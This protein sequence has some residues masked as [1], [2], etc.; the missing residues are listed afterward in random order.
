MKTGDSARNQL[1][2][3]QHLAASRFIILQSYK[4]VRSR[5]SKHS[6]IVA[7]R[8]D[9]HFARIPAPETQLRGDQAQG[10]RPWPSFVRLRSMVLLA[11]MIEHIYCNPYILHP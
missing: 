6:T 8:N 7:V 10:I 11:S 4:F 1:A 5:C 3:S 9:R 2:A